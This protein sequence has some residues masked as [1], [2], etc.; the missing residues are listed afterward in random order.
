MEEIDFRVKITREQF[1]EMCADLFERVTDPI[2]EALK[3]A[4]MTMVT[5]LPTILSYLYQF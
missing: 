1:E 3:M 5:R 2:K 4:E